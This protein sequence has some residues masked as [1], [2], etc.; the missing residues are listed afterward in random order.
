MFTIVKWYHT[1]TIAMV[2][3]DSGGS[4]CKSITIEKY[5][6]CSLISSS[7]HAILIPRYKPKD[8]SGNITPT[9]RWRHSAVIKKGKQNNQQT[10]WQLASIRAA[11]SPPRTDP[12][13]YKCG[14][15]WS[16]L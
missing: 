1:E 5:F 2:W 4:Q 13:K 3:L 12:S 14:G 6:G 9:L 16:C 10:R 8:W 7:T 15:F 11:V